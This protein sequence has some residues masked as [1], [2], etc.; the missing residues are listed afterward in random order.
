MSTI[1]T[2]DNI[3][4]EMDIASVDGKHL[5]TYDKIGYFPSCFFNQP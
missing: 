1:T 5:P 4:P 2:P 3:V